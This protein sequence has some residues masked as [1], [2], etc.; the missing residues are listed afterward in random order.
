LE[1]RR[2]ESA[3]AGQQAEQVLSAEPTNLRA[4]LVRARAWMNMAQYAKAREELTAVLRAY[5]ETKDARFELGQL[6]LRERRYGEAESEFQ[7]LLD[8]GDERG[9]AGAIESRVQQGRWEQ[10]IRL[11]EDLE[12]SA[13]DRSDYRVAAAQV[14]FRAG[15][16]AQSA[17]QFES[18]LNRNPNSEEL[19]LSLGECRARLGDYRAAIAAFLKARERAPNDAAADLALAIAYDQARMLSDARKSYEDALRKQPDNPVALNNLA[20]LDL[21]QGLN[22]DQALAYAQRAR[23][24]LPDDPNVMDTLGLIY[25]RKNLLDDGL[26]I[27]R[28]LVSRKPDSATFHLH[29]AL[30]LYQTGDRRSARKELESAKRYKPTGQEQTKIKELLA[31]VG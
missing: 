3:I 15:R 10:A 22:L 18:L 30:A 5:P 1:L 14:L 23:A 6:N 7:A 25:V 4:R 13:P 2:G 28:E 11:I 17:G 19:Y 24:K 9:L 12:K 27:L 8:A 31:K 21:E 16:Y 20:N 26:R 29:L